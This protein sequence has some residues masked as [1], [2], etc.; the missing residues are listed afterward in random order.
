MQPPALLAYA[1][2][3]A[4]PASGADAVL[5]R[6]LAANHVWEGSQGATWSVHDGQV[7]LA[8]DGRFRFRTL[9]PAALHRPHAARRTPHIHVKV[10]LGGRELLT[11]QFSVQGDPGNARDAL[12][13]R[14][15][16]EAQ[17]ALA[18]PFVP[19]PDGFSADSAVVVRT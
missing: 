19:G 6:L 15:D 3:G 16:A 7:T 14:L 10:K 8:R 2:V 12:W 9:K 1:P 4:L 5:R 11:T 18:R 13:R 17:A